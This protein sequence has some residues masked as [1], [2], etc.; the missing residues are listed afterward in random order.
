MNSIQLIKK[1]IRVKLWLN[2]SKTR[3]VNVNYIDSMPLISKIKNI[4]KNTI[5]NFISSIPEK[6]SEALQQFIFL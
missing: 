1:I 3:L 2:C 6:F 4:P 5:T